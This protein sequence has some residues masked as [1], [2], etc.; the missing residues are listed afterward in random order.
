MLYV[1]QGPDQF[2]AREE[3]SKIRASLDREGNLAHNTVW[4]EGR[5][6]TASDFQAA[7]HTHSFFAEDGRQ[8]PRPTR[9]STC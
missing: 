9:L 1:L 2:R 4:L 7:C 6:L 3:L 5:T 8:A